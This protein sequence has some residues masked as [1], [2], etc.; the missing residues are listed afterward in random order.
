MQVQY[1]AMLDALQAHE[2]SI[3]LT[4]REPFDESDKTYPMVVVDEIL[5][6]PESHGTVNGEERSLQ[7]YQLDIYTST[8]KTRTGTV[9][10]RW[11]AARL[12]RKEVSEF[13]DEQFKI[14][15]RSWQSLPQDTDVLRSVW[16]GDCVQDS[17]GYSYRP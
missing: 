16:R 10:N 13:L 4:F 5:N 6:L 9:L 8:C 2:F 3:E 7:G 11:Q 17:Y 12:L 15:R 1:D 14:T